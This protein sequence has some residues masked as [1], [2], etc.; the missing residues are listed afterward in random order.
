MGIT[1]EELK[2]TP[3]S[4]GVSFESLQ[5]KEEEEEEKIKGISFESLKKLKED[6]GIGIGENIWRT[7]VGALRD[8]GQGTIDFTDWIESKIPTALQAGLVKT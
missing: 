3:I 7:A 6:E 8:V 4:K 5:K 2:T 1:F